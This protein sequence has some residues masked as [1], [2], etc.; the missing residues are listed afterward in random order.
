MMASMVESIDPIVSVHVRGGIG[1]VLKVL[2][3][4]KD[5]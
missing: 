3:N 5:C 2:V 1:R 4:R